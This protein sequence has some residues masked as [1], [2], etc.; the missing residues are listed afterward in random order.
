[1]SR[2]KKIK[3]LNQVHGKQE[4]KQEEKFQPTTLDQI[5]G[6]SGASKYKTMEESVYK[7]NLAGMNKSDLQSHASK[8]GIIP[9]DDR[10][11]L[12]DRLLKEFRKY[13]SE[14]RKPSNLATG[15][16]ATPTREALDILSQGR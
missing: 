15:K 10:I 1:M 13:V 16:N 7:D 5:L 14:Y 2:P 12:T 4:E 9:I 11:R 6:D 8:I 3:E